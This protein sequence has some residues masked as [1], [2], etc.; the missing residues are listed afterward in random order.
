MLISALI[1]LDGGGRGNGK[2]IAGID[3]GWIDGDL[4]HSTNGGPLGSC[5]EFTSSFD[6]HPNQRRTMQ[7]IRFERTNT[8]TLVAVTIRDSRFGPQLD[9][10]ER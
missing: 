6:I 3:I 9:T 2:P 8:S 7:E 5:Q 10:G 4:T 1:D